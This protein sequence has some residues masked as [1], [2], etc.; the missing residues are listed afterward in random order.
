MNKQLKK[1]I[2]KPN[3]I[4]SKVGLGEVVLECISKEMSYREISDYIKKNYSTK[5]SIMAISRYLTT[6]YKKALLTNDI[7]ERA[8]L[9]LYSKTTCKECRRRLLDALIKHTNNSK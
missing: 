2:R 9:I 4:I 1:P 7:T 8:L 6:E 3:S 5:I